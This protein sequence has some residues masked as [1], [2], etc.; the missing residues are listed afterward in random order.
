MRRRHVV[1]APR[2]PGVEQLLKFCQIRARFSKKIAKQADFA[3][4]LP[5]SL[6]NWQ[7]I[8][9]SGPEGAACPFRWVRKHPQIPIT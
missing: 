9:K 6:P 2:K 5:K 4:S 8:S 1:F 3:K 7:K